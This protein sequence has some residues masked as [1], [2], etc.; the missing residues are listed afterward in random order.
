MDNN[1]I[2]LELKTVAE[3]AIALLQPV[4]SLIQG[5]LPIPPEYPHKDFCKGVDLK[6]KCMG[7]YK[8]WMET[9]KQ[10]KGAIAT[11]LATAL[12][13]LTALNTEQTGVNAA[14][15]ALS[16]QSLELANIAQ[17]AIELLLKKGEYNEFNLFVRKLQNSIDNIYAASGVTHTE[18]GSS[19]THETAIILPVP[20]DSS[21][22]EESI[23]AIQALPSQENEETTTVNKSSVRKGRNSR[24]A[25]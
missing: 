7:C 10:E 2:I 14:Y 1:Q 4:N 20:E 3:K 23:Q 5:T 17:M 8:G 15:E 21:A 24:K 18:N 9:Q 11:Q 13:Q 12:E 16:K 6:V 25:S 19:S 22:R